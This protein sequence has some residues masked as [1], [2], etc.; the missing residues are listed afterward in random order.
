MKRKYS[1]IIAA[2]KEGTQYPSLRALAKLPREQRPAEVLLAVGNNPP[3]QRNAAA[4]IA[5][6]PFLYFLDEDSQPLPT[7]AA[8]L[9][10]H[11]EEETVL[12]AGGPNVVPPEAPPFEKTVASVLA[13][14]MGSFLVR[15]RYAPLGAVRQATEKDLILCNLMVRKNLFL[16]L[17]GFRESLFPNEENEF[18]NRALHHGYRLIYDPG[19][20]IWRRPRK[21]FGE[22]SY[23]AF[24]YGRGRAQQIRTYPC[25]SDFV[26]FVPSFFVLYLATLPL[27]VS[28]AGVL[29]AISPL[30]IFVAGALATGLA[31]AS[32]NRRF[33]EIF[34]V[35]ALIFLRHFFYGLGFGLGL[36]LPQ[37]K[38]TQSF[39]RLFCA[40]GNRFQN[41]QSVKEIK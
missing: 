2:P 8:R 6:S 26:H 9:L 38:K 10:S 5:R 18:L 31:C 21:S 22:F 27:T 30:S 3:A 7:T 19:A 16:S 13:S 35:P 11:F 32:W 36:F 15:N 34:L 14:W 17:G 28:W 24:R 25:F 37:R 41:L 33:S 4:R 40:T 29:P 12:A 1:V 39:V 23:Q 20:V